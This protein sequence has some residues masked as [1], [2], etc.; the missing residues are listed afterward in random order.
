M[1]IE[2]ATSKYFNDT[3]VTGIVLYTFFNK[4]LTKYYGNAFFRE[5]VGI[6]GFKYQ[7]GRNP[8]LTGRFYTTLS[9]GKEKS[10][11]ICSKPGIIYNAVVWYEQ[12]A[13]EEA[14]ELLLKYEESKIQKLEK[15]IVKY[16]E[17]VDIIR[18]SSIVNGF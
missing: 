11:Q 7:V 1:N 13:D 5:G 6:N 8:N 18:S 3:T 9:N 17:L 12:D 15:E 16:K 14:R 4:K 10:F 2:V